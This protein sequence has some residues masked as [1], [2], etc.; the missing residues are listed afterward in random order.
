LWEI[1]FANLNMLLATIPS[2]EHETNDKDGEKTVE[3]LDEID[4]NYF[5]L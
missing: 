4:M 1:S 3:G 2:Y 5:G